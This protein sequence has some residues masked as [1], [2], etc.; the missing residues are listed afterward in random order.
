[1]KFKG[2]VAGM[3][4]DTEIGLC[5][6][7]KAAT[8]R[9][10]RY[11]LVVHLETTGQRSP[12]GSKC[13]VLGTLGKLSV[14]SLPPSCLLSVFDRASFLFG[15][16]PSAEAGDSFPSFVGAVASF[17]LGVPTTLIDEAEM[18]LGPSPGGMGGFEEDC[19][20]W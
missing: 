11:L 3:A 7:K 1:M 12:L 16:R 9:S 20:R 8:L 6:A 18:F 15:I 19:R 10:I 17:A 5:V 2:A 13:C 14:H 4:E